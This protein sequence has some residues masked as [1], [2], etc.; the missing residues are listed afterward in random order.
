MKERNIQKENAKLQ[1]EADA[2]KGQLQAAQLALKNDDEAWRQDYN[3]ISNENESL[4]GEINS[5]KHSMESLKQEKVTL[6]SE[7]DSIKQENKKLKTE[8]ETT[9]QSHQSH[10]DAV[11]LSHSEDDAEWR[12][13]YHS[14]MEK[15]NSLKLENDKLLRQQ[16]DVALIG[17]RTSIEKLED[18]ETSLQTATQENMVLKVANEEAEKEIMLLRNDKSS[19]SEERETANKGLTEIKTKLNSMVAD[20]QQLQQSAFVELQ[21]SRKQCS[22]PQQSLYH[23]LNNVKLQLTDM[24]AENK[25]MHQMYGESLSEASILQTELLSS[26]AQ[27][28]MQKELQERNAKL[29]QMK[30]R[31]EEELKS[32]IERL[33]KYLEQDCV[34][35]EQTHS[36][37]TTT[38]HS[39]YSKVE[40]AEKFTVSIDN[41]SRKEV[42]CGEGNKTC[43]L[44]TADP[45]M[46]LSASLYQLRA[47]CAKSNE[48]ISAHPPSHTASLKQNS[49]ASVVSNQAPSL[50]SASAS[51]ITT[52]CIRN[53]VGEELVMCK[54]I[55]MPDLSCGQR[56]VVQRQD[57]T[58]QYGTV[59]ALP[60]FV[61][62]ELDLPGMYVCRNEWHIAICYSNYFM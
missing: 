3:K 62:V 17:R 54:Q 61:G 52:L 51:S 37:I 12:L 40:D 16:L 30:D 58:Y 38:N 39:E 25:R 10:I 31:R 13:E 47:C 35:V 53:S 33:S 41:Y 23:E 6:E 22:T 20:S 8:N 43:C 44:L 4:K 45:E 59:Q 48:T 55:T 18:L 11:L 60:N 26:E 24:R 49:M 42:K 1:Q 27:L 50:Q 14:L 29:L 5:L 32:T 9:R 36:I 2:F 46:S 19:F 28:T 57:D 15:C 7:N 56:V 21:H 34:R